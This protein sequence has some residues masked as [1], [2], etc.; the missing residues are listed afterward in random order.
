MSSVYNKNKIKEKA[1]L[2]CQRQGIKIIQELGHGTQ[3]IVYQSSNNSAIKVYDL[4]DGYTRERN[5]YIRLKERLIFSIQN[6]KVP[7]LLNWDDDLFALEMSIVHVPCV[8][9]FG[10][11]Y[12]DNV[13][14]HL[15]VRD[16]EWEKEKI[17]EFESNWEDAKS[18]IREIELKGDLWLA[19]INTGNIK[20]EE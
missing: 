19:D 17:E 6:F 1:I 2:Y 15:P 13:P 3:G 8:L 10:G 16:E 4:F 14:K 11:A 9:D 5:V 12:L 7:R 18:I 20:F